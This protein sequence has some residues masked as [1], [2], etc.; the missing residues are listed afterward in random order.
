MAEFRE[1][2]HVQLPN[3]LGYLDVVGSGD[4]AAKATAELK[5]KLALT[6]GT[7]ITVKKSQEVTDISTYL[8]AG[9]SD[10]AR[11]ARLVVRKSGDT[12]APRASKKIR[13]MSSDFAKASDPGKVDI[14]AQAVIDYGAAL[15]DANGNTGFDVL[16]GDYVN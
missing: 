6:S 3:N 10:T 11:D 4:T 14:T 12:N 2:A 13:M 9:A 15:T 1:T 8:T 16:F 5:A 7:V